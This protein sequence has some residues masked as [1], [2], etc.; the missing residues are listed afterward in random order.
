MKRMRKRVTAFILAFIM[1]F[2]T[3]C[4][5]G[6]YADELSGNSVSVSGNNTEAEIKNL[7]KGTFQ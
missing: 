2:T 7:I 5:S 4:S 1:L 3:G 6:F